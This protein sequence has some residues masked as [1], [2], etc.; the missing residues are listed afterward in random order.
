MFKNASHTQNKI[1]FIFGLQ[2]K[3][4]FKES[5]TEITGNCFEEE[6]HMGRTV[7]FSSLMKDRLKK[8]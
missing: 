4:Q 2:G 1:F 3:V 8:E 6:T 5:L 7:I